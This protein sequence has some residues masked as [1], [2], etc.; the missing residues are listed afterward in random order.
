MK[1]TGRPISV[2]TLQIQEFRNG[3]VVRAWTFENG[4]TIPT[5]LGMLAH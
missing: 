1:S 5:Q 3:K 4:L 2:H